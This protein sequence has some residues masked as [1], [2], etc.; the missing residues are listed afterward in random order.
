MSSSSQEKHEKVPI[1]DEAS[2]GSIVLTTS[3]SEP[4][5]REY[6]RLAALC[7]FKG[8]GRRNAVPGIL[9][10][11]GVD[12]EELLAAQRAL[13]TATWISIFFLITTDIL[14]PFNAPFA[15]SQVGILGNWFKHLC[16]VLQSWQLIVN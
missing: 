15:F 11:S 2:P 3:G 12:K 10:K 13:R 4:T 7:P 6:V 9:E 1:E 14:G 5:L 16:T 8:E